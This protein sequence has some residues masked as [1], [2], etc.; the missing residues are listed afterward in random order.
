MNQADPIP[1]EIIRNAFLAAAEDMKTTLWRSAFSPVIYEM[2]DCSIALFDSQA[3]LLAQAP[4]LPFFLGALGEIVQVVV[5]HVGFENLREGDAYILNDPYLTGS[6]INDVDILS[7]VV[8]EGDVVGFVVT[9]AHW[10]DMGAKD[11]IYAIDSTEI[12]QEGLRLG[13]VK[14][15]DRGQVIADIADIIARNSRLPHSTIGDLHAQIAAC[16]IGERRFH[17]ILDRFGRET[18]QISMA[19]V[20]DTTEALEREAVAAIPDGV[21]EALGHVDNDYQ[22][23]EPI[24]IKVKVTIQGSEITVDTYGSSLQRPGCTNCGLVQTLSAIR[25]AFKFLFRPDIGV[26]GGSFRSL[27]IEVEPGSIFAAQEPAAC[28]QYGTHTMLMVDLMI[29]ALSDVMPNNVAAGLPGNAWNVIGVDHGPDGRVRS[30]WGEATAGGWGASAFNDGASA[31][32][33]TAAGDFRNLPVES[34]ENKFPIR[35]RRYALGTDS[36][37]PGRFRGG[38][39]I[40]REYEVAG[41]HLDVSLWFDRTLTPQW[42]L[43]GGQQGAVPRVLIHPDTDEEYVLLKVNHMPTTRNMVFRVHTGGGGGYGPAWERPAEQVHEDLLDGYISHE[44]AEKD[45]LVGFK[46]GSLQI[47]HEATAAA[48]K[49]TEP[50]E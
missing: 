48:R 44:A 3:Q 46:N 8:Y 41:D 22:S 38:L 42:G 49:Q 19:S 37:G 21:Y 50:T 43:F 30:A 6:H 13:P 36:G 2:K 25:C 47:D 5:E 27:T 23:D 4:G 32:I 16:R 17:E 40:V 28:L 9:R 26:T 14:L 15:A 11:A 35:I 10:L 45:Y 31:V 39:N 34:M 1:T 29:K 12:Y 20:F 33:H 7:P 18:T 24:P